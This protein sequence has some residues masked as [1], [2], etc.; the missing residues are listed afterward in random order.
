MGGI[1][2]IHR[3]HLLRI[4]DNVRFSKPDDSN[5]IMHPPV[6]R[7][8]TVKRRPKKQNKDSVDMVVG[9][10]CDTTESDDDEDLCHYCELIHTNRKLPSINLL[11]NLKLCL[12]YVSMCLTR[13]VLGQK[14]RQRLIPDRSL[15]SLLKSQRIWI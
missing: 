1:R 11:W 3:D 10:T 13:S 12:L 8:R 6:T 7:A 15:I 2:T 9:E 4:G 14:T 5:P